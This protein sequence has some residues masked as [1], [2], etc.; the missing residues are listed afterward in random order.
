MFNNCDPITNGEIY[1]FEKLKNRISVFFDVGSRDDTY[2]ASLDHTDHIQFH[3]FEPNIDFFNKI[4]KTKNHILNNV[5]LGQEETELNYYEGAQSFVYRKEHYG[6]DI[7]FRKFKIMRLDDYCT[8]NAI[9]HIEF[10]K[11][12]TEGFELDVLIGAEKMLSNITYIQFEYGGTYIDRKINLINVIDTLSSGGFKFFYLLNGNSN[13]VLQSDFSDHYQYSNYLATKEPLNLDTTFDVYALCF[14]EVPI[15]PA[16]LKHY[17]QAR[18]IIVYDNESSDGSQK[19]IKDLGGVL[20]IFKTNGQFN[21]QA[22]AYLKN[23]IWKKSRGKV[24]FVIV[25]DM[26]EFLH[27]PQF[28]NDIISVLDYMKSNNITYVKCEGYEMLLDVNTPYTYVTE[29]NWKGQRDKAYDK[30]LVFNPCSILESNFSAGSHSFSP[31]IAN[32]IISTEIIKA[33]LLHYKHLGLE[34]EIERRLRTGGTRMSELNKKNGWS[35]EYSLKNDEMRLYVEKFYDPN[36]LRDLR[37][38]L[39]NR[40]I[41]TGTVPYSQDSTGLAGFLGNQLFMICSILAKSYDE[42]KKPYFYYTLGERHYDTT[43]F[44][45]LHFGPKLNDTTI[46]HIHGYF[47]SS[48]YFIKHW[49]RISNLL[50]FDKDPQTLEK[51]RLYCGENKAICVHVR[52]GDYK[53]L[54]WELPISYYK[55]AMAQFEGKFIIFT[56]EIEWCRDHFADC[57]IIEQECPDKTLWLMSKMDGYIIAN[58]TFSWWGAFL[59]TRDLSKKVIAPFPWFKNYSYDSDIYEKDWIK[60]NV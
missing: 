50:T 23:M 17:N 31:I 7:P 15:L 41:L 16:F 1:L 60:I 21:D 4:C 34:W 58:S 55:E 35:C 5:G 37:D 48:K 51:I 54:K 45:K 20:N 26:D 29:T 19:L 47:Q 40:P 43:I 44:K 9:S 13:P 10:L 25:Q 59:G 18:E 27:F 24:D 38:I 28:P 52:R 3:L 12:D 32:S 14:N 57:L 39:D 33:Q 2:Y 56:D 30:V 36:N 6:R 53:N 22:H 46:E 42:N 11:I 49:E 8:K